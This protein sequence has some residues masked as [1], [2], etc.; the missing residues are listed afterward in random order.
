MLWKVKN[1]EVYLFGGIHTLKPGGNPYRLQL[2]NIYSSVEQLVFECN[3]GEDTAVKGNISQ[4]IQMNQYPNDP[5]VKKAKLEL[6][7]LGID[8]RYF[9]Q[10]SIFQV[11]NVIASMKYSI[12]GYSNSNSADFM[13]CEKAGI[14]KKHI[15]Y[16]EETDE[17]APCCDNT[18]F[19]QQ[20]EFLNLVLVPITEFINE[21]EALLDVWSKKDIASMLTMFA[22][23]SK[24][25]PELGNCLIDRR[26]RLWVSRFNEIVVSDVP[27]LIIVGVLH[28][29]YEENSLQTLLKQ[30][31]G[32]TFEMITSECLLEASS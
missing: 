25:S 16:F 6:E 23:I 8:L 28:C 1:T 21:H 22:E 26:N 5:S 17:V 19:E 13:Y 32:H 4:G 14:D 20:V 27:T 30:E 10:A 3:L 12:C 7:R 11:A 2:D 15:L 31:Y 24:K 9:N 18:P 29:I